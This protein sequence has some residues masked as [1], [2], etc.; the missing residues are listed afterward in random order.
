M[1]LNIHHRRDVRNFS[2]VNV[3]AH[4]KMVRRPL[5]CRPFAKESPPAEQKLMAET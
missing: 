1:I 5:V 2:I 4:S 3:R